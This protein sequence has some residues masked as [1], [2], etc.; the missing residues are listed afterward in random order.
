MDRE[1]VVYVYL[2]EFHPVMKKNELFPSV[3]TWTDP[4]RD[5]ER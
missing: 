2:V 5:E 3:T 1:N 4:G